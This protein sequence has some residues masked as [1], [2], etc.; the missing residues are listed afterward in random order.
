MRHVWRHLAA[1]LVLLLIPVFARLGVWQLDRAEEGEA[2]AQEVRAR[3]LQPPLELEAVLSDAE[4]AVYRH[5][6][7]RGSFEPAHGVLLD[8]HKQDGWLG[9][10]VIV[11]FRL[12]GSDVR[13]L[14]NRG[15][16]P[17]DEAL[18]AA[19]S[20]ESEVRGILMRPSRPALVL[21]KAGEP[22]AHWGDVWP[23]LDIAYFSRLRGYPVQPLVL[24]EDPRVAREVTEAAIA[25]GDKWGMHIGYAVQWFAFAI[26]ALVLA[27]VLWRKPREE[28]P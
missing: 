15:W 5:A 12:A 20:E 10:H 18:R 21:G 13:V 24:V 11:P 6:L 3:V 16:Q 9:F 17:R 22:G 4:A 28:H 23:Y 25:A 8:N 26:L 14:V 7:A 19:F 27:G 2:L 1:L